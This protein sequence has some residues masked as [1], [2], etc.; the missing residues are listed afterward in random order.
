M[1]NFLK[2]VWAWIMRKM[3]YSVQ[4]SARRKRLGSVDVV[5]DW[6]EHVAQVKDFSKFEIFKRWDDNN[7]IHCNIV[8]SHKNMFFIFIWKIKICFLFLF[9]K[10]KNKYQACLSETNLFQTK[11]TSLFT[12]ACFLGSVI[13]SDSSAGSKP[14][15]EQA[16]S[17][18]DHVTCP[19]VGVLAPLLWVL[20]TGLAFYLGSLQ[21]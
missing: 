14:R 16:R 5:M 3:R 10:W 18:V 9:E 12:P 11:T 1:I 21:S 7:C 19:S 17:L 2:T 6:I 4:A 8:L 20:S 13:V 15:P